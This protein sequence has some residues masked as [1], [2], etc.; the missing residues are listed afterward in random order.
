MS[1]ADLREILEEIRD[2]AREGRSWRDR[3]E[4]QS[5]ETGKLLV[6]LSTQLQELERIVTIQ[7]D[8]GRSR[9]GSL[10]GRIAVMEQNALRSGGGAVDVNITQGNQTVGPEAAATAARGGTVKAVAG[11]LGGGGALTWLIGGGWQQIVEFI[12]GLGK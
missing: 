3:A 2:G 12:K 9:F 7:F 4:A 6:V 1:E 8:N 11:G 10:E 5:V